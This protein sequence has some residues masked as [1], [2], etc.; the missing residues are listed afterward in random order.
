MKTGASKVEAKGRQFR[1]TR[2][3]RAIL[4]AVQSSREHPTADTVYG[5]VR[6][7]LP[8]ISLG[9]VYRNL[10]TLARAG[11]IGTVGPRG[12][13]MRFDGTLERHDHIRCVDCGKIADVPAAA[14]P[15][16]DAAARK[17]CDF[18]ILGHA[19]EFQG[20]CRQCR[21]QGDR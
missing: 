12:Q 6:T 14:L 17:G 11:L 21:H 13:R 3:R 4:E 15:D 9:T 20:R 10:E 7:R 8:R 1:M 19:L 18:E 2:Q 16:L 5:R